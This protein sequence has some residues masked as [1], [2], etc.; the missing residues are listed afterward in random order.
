M[1]PNWV[2]KKQIV[3]DHWISF[4]MFSSKATTKMIAK[5]KLWSF[6]RIDKIKKRKSFF[7]T[8]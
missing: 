7:K 1:Y 3:Y 2:L 4:L 5:T 8:L 6:G